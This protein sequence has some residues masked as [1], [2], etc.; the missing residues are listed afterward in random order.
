MNV[1]IVTG[2]RR[3]QGGG[4]IA[5]VKPES[6]A[7]DFVVLLAECDV[8][9]IMSACPNDVIPGVNGGNCVEVEYEVMGQ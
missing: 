5:S 3:E 1:P 8:V 2:L 9:A 4:R 7:G 6:K